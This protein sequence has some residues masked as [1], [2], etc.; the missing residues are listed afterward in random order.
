MNGRR[1]ARAF[2]GLVKIQSSLIACAAASSMTIRAKRLECEPIRGWRQ[3][4]ALES[5]RFNWTH[6]GT[7]CFLG[8]LVRQGP[9]PS[10][11]RCDQMP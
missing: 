1:C 7:D 4:T 9:I 8:R 2:W 5:V 11:L 6:S 3:M 10:L